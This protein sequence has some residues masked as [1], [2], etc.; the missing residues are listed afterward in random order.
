MSRS[1]IGSAPKPTLVVVGAATRDVDP[2]DPRGWKLGGG[3][4]Y[5]A[6]AAARL[7]V[8]VRALVGAD[9]LAATAHELDALRDAGVA[10]HVQEL[11]SGPVFDNRRTPN[12]R[13]QFALAA[14]DLLTPAML[15]EEWHAP[16]SALLAP[17]A[18]ELAED[19]STAFAPATFVTLA[20]QG[21]LRRL[22][23]GREVVRLEFEH[24]PVI[25]RA[26]AIAI[27]PEDVPDGAP[28][29]RDW[30]RPGQHVLMTHGKRGCVALTRTS[31]GLDGVFMPP[32][33]PRKAVDPTGAGDTFVAAWLAARMLVGDGWRPLAIASV[34]SSLAVMTRSISDMPTAA[35]IC[36]EIV[37]LRDSR[38]ASGS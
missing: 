11:A 5:S 17:V 21:L 36:R 32:L 9:E 14:S 22:D 27:S 23:P 7:G 2:S 30:T 18:G 29:I 15:P 16:D 1:S 10:V 28:P 4:T 13:V 34:M 26:D 8:S 31:S 25:H 12:G 19:W 24:G 37:T 6:M 20:A 33:P 3:V 35:D 38:A